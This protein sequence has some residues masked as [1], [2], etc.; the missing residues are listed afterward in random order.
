MD[1]KRHRYI[2]CC[3][4]P[5]FSLVSFILL[6][7]RRSVY[8]T[9]PSLWVIPSME[10]FPANAYIL[11]VSLQIRDL[12]V[13]VGATNSGMDRY[14]ESRNRCH[15]CPKLEHDDRLARHEI[16]S[17]SIPPTNMDAACPAHHFLPY[18]PLK[19]ILFYLAGVLATLGLRCRIV[20]F[21]ENSF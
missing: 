12:L 1:L 18:W 19:A 5:Q 16:I 17:S 7:Y 21:G 3:I 6:I 11:L 20:N 14:R 15:V 4:W 10:D 13:E 2:Q 9:I 8:R